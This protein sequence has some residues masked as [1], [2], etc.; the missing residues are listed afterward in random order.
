MLADLVRARWRQILVDYICAAA[1]WG[2]T[3]S[4]A[5]VLVIRLGRLTSSTWAAT[6]LVVG[7]ALAAAVITAWR[8]RPDTLQVAIL[9]DLRLNLKEK[10]STA[11]EFSLGD[12]NEELAERLATQAVKARHF[13][14]HK[15]LFPVRLSQWGKLAPIAGALL[16]F[17]HVIDLHRF[18]EPAAPVVDT[19]LVREGARLREYG[20][21]MEHRAKRETWQRSLDSSQRMQRL[22]D[23]MKSARLSRREALSHLG[24]M[25]ATLNEARRAALQEGV[26]KQIG[27]LELEARSAASSLRGLDLRGMLQKLLQGQ[28]EA[29]DL[30]ALSDAPATLSMLGITPQELEQAMAGFA[31]GDAQKL[32]EILEDLAERSQSIQEA[33]ELQQAREAVDRARENLGER[34][35]AERW[36]GESERPPPWAGGEGAGAPPGGPFMD[37][38]APQ[39]GQPATAKGSGQSPTGTDREGLPSPSPA[40]EAGDQVLKPEAQMREGP[41]FSSVARALPRAARPGLEKVELDPSFAAQLEEVLA[42][43]EYPLH[44]KEYMRRYFLAISEGMPSSEGGRP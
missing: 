19:T 38:P 22:G 40:T 32:R 4:C 3:I 31:A 35:A 24:A 44:F 43:E 23:R 33:E 39:E 34:D 41:V 28:L 29:R 16:L 15:R 26:Q 30:A 20:L 27:P 18:A 8:R 7:V 14:S 25:G 10:V 36:A 1:F 6:A 12:H 21:Q 9:A 37:G 13:L 17:V 11:W 42:K 5:T 2:L